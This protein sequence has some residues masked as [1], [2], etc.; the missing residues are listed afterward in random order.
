M[1]DDTQQELIFSFIVAAIIGVA[2]ICGVKGCT[3]ANAAPKDPR[4]CQWVGIFAH[5][6]ELG[7][8]FQPETGTIWEAQNALN[9]LASSKSILF[10]ATCWMPGEQ[11]EI[12]LFKS[13]KGEAK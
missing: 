3:K 1:S 12:D 5:G 10:H 13:F 11:P 8:K 9:K 4:I 2:V 6:G 7:N